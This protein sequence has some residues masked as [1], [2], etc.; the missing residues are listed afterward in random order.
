M[1]TYHLFI[2]HTWTH[3]DRYE[4]L[5]ELLEE[6]PDFDFKDYSVPKDDPVHTTGTDAELY[7]AIRNKMRLCS[8]VLIFAG[9]DATYSKW[10]KKEVRI[11]KKEFTDPKPIIA[12]EPRGSERTSTFIKE[13]ADE[14]VGW[15]TESIVSAIR[16][17]G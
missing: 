13:N 7:Q 16:K 2:S 17:W 12:I 4:R 3:S 6:R 1:K 10:V 9:V 8:V 14:I 5:I 11:A 15:N